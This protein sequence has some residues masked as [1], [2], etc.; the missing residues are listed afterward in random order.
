MSIEAAKLYESFEKRILEGR[1]KGTLSEQDED[2]LLDEMDDLWL[3]MTDEEQDEAN[4]RAAE[5]AKKHL[6]GSDGSNPK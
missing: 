1:A 5:W 2:V 6:E 4:R 3:A